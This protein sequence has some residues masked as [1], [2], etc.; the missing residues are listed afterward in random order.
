MGD[1]RYQG[2]EVQGAMRTEGVT[3]GRETGYPRCKSL[4]AWPESLS[5]T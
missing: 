1:E 4:G 5:K 2:H 3:V